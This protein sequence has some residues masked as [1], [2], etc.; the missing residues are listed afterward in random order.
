MRRWAL[1]VLLLALLPVAQAQVWTPTINPQPIEDMLLSAA[2]WA[3]RIAALYTIGFAIAKLL[4]GRA[5]VGSGLP[6]VTMRG[7]QEVWEAF[8]NL[9]WF[10]LAIVL[11]PFFLYVVASAGLLP[12][13]VAG[14]MSRII[15]GLWNWSI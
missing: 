4:Y 5:Q 1:L 3:L 8:S 11:L 7:H 13:W 2:R 14:L 15:E 10:A 9:F 6:G 12:Q